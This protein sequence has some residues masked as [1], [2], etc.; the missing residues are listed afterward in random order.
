MPCLE[1]V[2][3][4]QREIPHKAIIVWK[5]QLCTGKQSL[6]TSPTWHQNYLWSLPL[7]QTPECWDPLRTYTQVEIQ[8]KFQQNFSSLPGHSNIW[9]E[10][11]DLIL[12][13][14]LQKLM[15]SFNLAI[16]FQRLI[17]KGS[18]LLLTSEVV[19]YYPDSLVYS[20][21]TYWSQ[22]VCPNY[23]EMLIQHLTSF[24]LKCNLDR[25]QTQRPLFVLAQTIYHSSVGRE[26]GIIFTHPHL[27]VYMWST[28]PYPAVRASSDS[29]TTLL[30]Q[31][32]R[33]SRSQLSSSE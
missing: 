12:A 11:P 4:V 10:L 9:I 30:R 13:I 25:I 16:I 33:G 6:N 3:L 8:E 28:D 31:G 26:V 2:C 21:D 19:T 23:L 20:V 29:S 22:A 24:K 17:T 27:Q 32:G 14:Q 15:C 1:P 7:G 18:P 5:L